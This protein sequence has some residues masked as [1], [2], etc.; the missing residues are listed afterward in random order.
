MPNSPI[1]TVL[2]LSFQT[3]VAIQLHLRD[4]PFDEIHDFADSLISEDQR[5][6]CLNSQFMII[7][8]FTIRHLPALEHVPNLRLDD[9]FAKIRYERTK[10][11]VILFNVP[12]NSCA[13]ITNL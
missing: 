6:N 12:K 4:I 3:S 5:K 7:L 13:L 2:L 11:F 9:L 1:G 10:I 8:Y